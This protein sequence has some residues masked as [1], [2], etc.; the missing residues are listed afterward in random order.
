V[1]IYSDEVLIELGDAVDTGDSI[2]WMYTA[3]KAVDVNGVRI[4]ARAYDRPYNEGVMEVV[5]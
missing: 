1:Y 2:M 4:V 3:T 5:I